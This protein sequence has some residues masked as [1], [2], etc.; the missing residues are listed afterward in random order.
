VVNTNRRN[1]SER[2][3]LPPSDTAGVESTVCVVN[4][5]DIETSATRMDIRPCSASVASC[6]SL[7]LASS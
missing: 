1:G 3:H 2:Q 5:S 6:V 4:A 7:S